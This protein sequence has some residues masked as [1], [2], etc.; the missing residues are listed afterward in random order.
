MYD[1]KN[2]ND[3]DKWN[4]LVSNSENNNI[5]LKSYYLD[6]LKDNVDYFIIKKK[7]EVISGFVVISDNNKNIV[8]NLFSIYSGI[9]FLKNVSMKSSAY[10]SQTFQILEHYQMFL[11]N[12]YKNI[13]ISLTPEVNDIRPFQWYNYLSSKEKRY[14][15]DIRYTSYLKLKNFDI[16]DE[17]K[18]DLLQN[19]SDTRK[20]NIKYGYKNNLEFSKGDK[21]TFMNLYL[22]SIDRQNINVDNSQLLEMENIISVLEKKNKLEIISSKLKDK[23]EYNVVVCWDDHKGYYLFGTGE[24]KIERYSA[25][26]TLWEAIKFLRAKDVDTLDLEGINSPTR[27]SFKTSFG[28]SIVPYYI[29][30]FNIY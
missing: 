19:L 4:E 5:F 6:C 1:I 11:N 27:G 21:K 20:Q 25:S 2:I 13:N 24:E 15:I 17:F 14:S 18:S 22:K 9:F 23:I 28:G 7:S 16:K 8:E 12:N 10:N 26:A 30:N 3:K 29:L